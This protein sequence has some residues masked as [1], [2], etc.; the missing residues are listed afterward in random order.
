MA[1]VIL[2]IK[3][4]LLEGSVG[5]QEEIIHALRERGISINQSKVSRLL[6][7]V[8]AVKISNERGESSYSLH[9]EPLPPSTESSLARLIVDVV[10]NE[11]M[12]VIHT[13]PGSA[14]LIARLLDYQ[15]QELAILG[16]V[17]GDD[18]LLVVP[19]STRHIKISLAAVK[20][21]LYG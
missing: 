15:T 4:L 21:R 6:R 9:R 17:A 13:N 5:T 11:T 8:G 18:T 7:R 14:S 20:K 16:T 12:I 10:A 3:D 1:D 19:K 2:A